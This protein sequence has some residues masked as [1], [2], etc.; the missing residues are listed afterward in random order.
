VDVNGRDEQGNTALMY[1]ARL[2]D[3]DEQRRAGWSL[4]AKGAE[5]NIRNQRGETALTLA[6]SQ[7]ARAGVDMLMKF[8]AE[9]TPAQEAAT[10]H[11]DVAL[12]HIDAEVTDHEGRILSDL[13]R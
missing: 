6:A 13:T 3:R 2:F 7:P 4:L 1:A 9:Q 11:A 12:V 8:G 10:F 5:V